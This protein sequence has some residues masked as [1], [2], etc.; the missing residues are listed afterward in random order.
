MPLRSAQFWIFIL[1]FPTRALIASGPAALVISKTPT[2]RAYVGSS[3][4]AVSAVALQDGSSFWSNPAVAADGSLVLMKVDHDILFTAFSSGVVKAS[5]LSDGKQL[6]SNAANR[7]IIDLVADEGG[8]LVVS[9]SQIQSL[10]TGGTLRWTVLAS[11]VLKAKSWVSYASDLVLGGA[12]FWASSVSGSEICVV[13][14][15]ADKKE[16][17]V[18]VLELATGKVLREMAVP[19]AIRGQ[20]GGKFL[21]V[22]DHM[23]AIQG[24]KLL[25]CPICFAAQGNVHSWDLKMV[26]VAGKEPNNFFLPWANTP[27]AF[28]VSNGYFTFVFRITSEGLKPYINN[29]LSAVGPVYGTS[30]ARVAMVAHKADYFHMKLLSDANSDAGEHTLSEGY[31]QDDHGEVRHVLVVETHTDKYVYL[32]GA[33]HTLAATDGSTLLWHH[34]MNGTAAQEAGQ[35][36]L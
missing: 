35:G 25:S 32:L 20:L 31:A 10:T 36:E 11:D 12:Q 30:A 5:Q 3:D 8:V 24:E 14:A 23:V 26:R 19:D 9:T 33:E 28:V 21:A 2:D 27:S 29:A 18:Q 4:G 15:T 6:W 34:Q 17:Y 22:G 7:K 1:V 13:A 16:A